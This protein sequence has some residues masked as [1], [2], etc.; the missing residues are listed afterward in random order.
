M[1]CLTHVSQHSALVT[2]PE[3]CELPTWSLACVTTLDVIASLIVKMQADLRRDVSSGCCVVGV[4]RRIPG[5]QCGQPHASLASTAST[6][7]AAELC[8]Q[9]AAASVIPHASGCV[10]CP[11]SSQHSSFCTVSHAGRCISGGHTAFH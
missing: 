9:S 1:Q 5:V 11:V 3:Q 8:E 4:G 6:V 7:I 10:S 2:L